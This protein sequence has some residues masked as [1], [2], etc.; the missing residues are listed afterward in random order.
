MS[1]RIRLEARRHEIVLARPLAEALA[2]AA[3]GAVLLARGWPLSFG[4]A[5]LLAVAAARL[6]PAVWRWERTRLV[7]TTDR[8]SVSYGTLRRRAAAVGLEHL[9]PIEVE[10]TLLGRLLGYGTV[11][12]GDLE[13]PYVPKPY[14]ISALLD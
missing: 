1:E 10:Q 11:T 14:E 8:L 5:F 7:I 2:L 3:A 9:G 4:G 13:I 12:A 6:L